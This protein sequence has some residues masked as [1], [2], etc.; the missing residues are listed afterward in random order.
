MAAGANN[1]FELLPLALWSAFYPTLL[2][3]VVLI[4]RRPDPRRLLLTYYIG[5]MV[6]SLTAGFLLI[7]AVKA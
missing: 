5:G 1:F 6:A 3:M 4:M 7:E 2:T